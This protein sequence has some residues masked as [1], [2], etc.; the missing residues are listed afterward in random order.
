MRSPSGLSAFNVNYNDARSPD[1]VESDNTKL[2]INKEL[3]KRWRWYLPLKYLNGTRHVLV[4]TENN[5]PFIIHHKKTQ[6]RIST[7][8]GL[9]FL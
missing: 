6:I 3:P 4:G 8:L 2:V 7:L 9:T 5:S 1:C